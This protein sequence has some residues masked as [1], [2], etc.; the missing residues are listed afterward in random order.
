MEI[1]YRNANRDNLQLFFNWANDPEVR[2][3][4]YNSNAI[5]LEEHTNW[6]LQKLDDRNTKFYIAEVKT[7][8]A[9]MVRFDSKEDHAIVSILIDKNFRGLGLA[10]T[11]LQDC[12]RFYFETESKPIHAYIKNSN[13]ASIHSFKKA[14]F[15]FLKNETVNGT[16][17][18]L[19]IKEKYHE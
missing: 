14:G 5:S 17:S 8:P 16:E 4:S 13:M 7:Q 3:N 11:L 12:C 1:N 6:Y 18:Q 2:N 19:F 15:S 10:S 9:G